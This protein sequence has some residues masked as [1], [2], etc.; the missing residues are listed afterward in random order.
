MR[1]IWHTYIQPI[2]DYCSQLYATVSGPLLVKLEGVLESFT[3]KIKGFKNLDFW[4]CL[5]KLKLQSFSRRSD[6]YRMIYCFKVLNKLTQN[7]DLEW[8]YD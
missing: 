4:K 2:F 7:C 6:R 8:E 1:W 3:A 5:A